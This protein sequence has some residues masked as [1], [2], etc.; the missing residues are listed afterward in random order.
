MGTA[1]ASL[2]EARLTA[3]KIEVDFILCEESPSLSMKP[4]LLQL[5]LYFDDHH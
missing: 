1:A 4:H 2:Q 5:P 3:T